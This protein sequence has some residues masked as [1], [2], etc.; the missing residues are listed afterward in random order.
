[1]N[2]LIIVMSMIVVVWPNSFTVV[3]YSVSPTTAKAQNAAYS[4]QFGTVSP[5]VRDFDLHI[6]FPTANYDLQPVSN[7]Q[8]Q[9]NSSPVSSATCAID[10]GA[11]SI[12]FSNLQLT[13]TINNMS[14]AFSTITANYA[15][16][17]TLSFNYY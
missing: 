5:F 1:M 13:Q 15:G 8:F 6:V 16:S 14:I 4:F 11:S 17:A 10:S 12:V 7:C 9:I 3:D 2:F